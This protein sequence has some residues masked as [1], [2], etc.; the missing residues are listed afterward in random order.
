MTNREY[1]MDHLSPLRISEGIIAIVYDIIDP[2]AVYVVGDD[3]VGKAMIR[4]L[5]EVMF[6]PKTKNVSES[7]FSITY[8]YTD[9]TR[10]YLTLCRKYGVKPDEEL[11]SMSGMSVIKDRT[12]KW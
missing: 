10:Y 1:I 2:N 7:G 8:D 6:M 4:V 5:E 11:V 3:A 12:S 9:L